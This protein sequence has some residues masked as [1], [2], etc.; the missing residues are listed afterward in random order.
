MLKGYS[1]WSTRS[2]VLASQNFQPKPTNQDFFHLNSRQRSSN[3]MFEHLSTNA[4]LIG[5]VYLWVDM[6]DENSMSWWGILSGGLQVTQTRSVLW[7]GEL[8]PCCIAIYI[9]WIMASSFAKRQELLLAK[10]NWGQSKIKQILIH[11]PFISFTH[12]LYYK[13]SAHKKCQCLKVN[14]SY[15]S[16][17]NSLVSS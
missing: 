4:H 12:N 6:C 7:F 11:L 14:I 16:V 9:V 2:F 3:E 8:L 17:H 13:P 15:A 10:K 5:F 1:K